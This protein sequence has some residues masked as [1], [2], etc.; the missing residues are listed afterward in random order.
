[1]LRRGAAVQVTGR[2]EI[3]ARYGPQIAVAAVA[4]AVEVDHDAL[5]DGPPRGA[6]QMEADL[7][8]LLG[9][10]PGRRTCACCSTRVLGAGLGDVGALPRRAGRQAL[11]PGLPPRPARALPRRRPGASAR[12]AAT[13]PGIDRDV[14]VTGALLHD[15]GKLEAYTA[16]RAARSTSPTPASCRARSRSA[17]T[18]SGALIEDID[19]FPPRRRAGACCTSSSATT[20]RSST[21]ARSCPCTREAT[22]VHMIDNLGGRLGQLRPAREGA[23]AG[24]ALVGLRPRDRRRRVLR[25]PAGRRASRQSR[26]NSGI[27]QTARDA[28]DAPRR[29]PRRGFSVGPSMAKDTEKLIRQL[30]L[31]SYLMAERRPVTALGDPARR[32]GLQRH[33]RGRVRAALL[34]RPRRAR[35]A[36]HPAHGRPAGR[37][38]RRAG[39]LLAARR[40]TSTCRRSR[41]P[42]RSS[43]RCR[44][45]S[46]CST[47]SSPTPSRCGSRCSRSP[48]AAR[49]R[50]R[51]PSSARSR[52]ASPPRPAA[53]ELS[54]RLAKVETAIFRRKTIVFDYYTMERDETGARKVDPYHLLFQG[55]QFY[56]LGHSHEREAIRVFRLVADPRQG[57]LR[58]EGR[59]RLPAPRRTSTRAPTPTAPT[60][61]SASQ[62]RRAE[63]WISERIAWQIE[64]H[65]GRYGELRP[66]ASDGERRSVFATEYAIA[67]PARRRGCSGSASTP[68]SLGPPELVAELRE[69]LDRVASCHARRAAELAAPRRPPARRP[70]R[71]AASRRRA[72]PPR[73]TPRSA[74]SASPGSSRSPRS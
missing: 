56:L 35:V 72:R 68:A 8:E 22:L 41:S 36:R 11:P 62:R 2:F 4:A 59:A 65:F 7:R 58:D 23:R 38:R 71:R 53:H 61:S 27:P 50:S 10:G 60:G 63:I 21:A 24:R 26:A 55:G 70:R 42:T 46:A 57:R 51:S 52:S 43:P 25:G 74:R 49:A 44:P 39:E 31:I 17:T 1:M 28:P 6:A 19:G 32:R 47:A 29:A 69:R 20:A 16:D 67:A 3:D 37:R 54:Q 12:S 15:I 5:L 33:E 14:A 18:A 73:A 64:R 13:F 45:R 34:R 30:S 40:R 9:H 48:G 66:G